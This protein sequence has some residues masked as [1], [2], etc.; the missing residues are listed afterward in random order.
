M[1]SCK[2]CKQELTRKWWLGKK[3]SGYHK[4]RYQKIKVGERERH[5][6]KKYGVDLARYQEMYS[7]QDGTVI[8]FDD[9]DKALA[10]AKDACLW[11]EVSKAIHV[12]ITHEGKQ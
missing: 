4:A 7:Q 10:W 1:A 11:M 12:T 5:L 2:S 9:L 6:V 3:Q 8:R